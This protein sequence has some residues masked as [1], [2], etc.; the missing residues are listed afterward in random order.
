MRRW[1]SY[2]IMCY[3][4]TLDNALAPK[5]ATRN[6][7]GLDLKA[8]SHNIVPAHGKKLIDIGIKI[9]LPSNT[10]GRI[11]GRSSLALNHFIEI[12]A[13]V[14]DLDYT[15]SLKVVMANHSDKDFHIS[16]GDKIAQLIVEKIFIP[17]IVEIKPAGS[18]KSP[19][20]AERLDRGFGSS[21]K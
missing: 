15:G 5:R 20:H 1:Q 11:A 19:G 18:K 14:V 9:Y 17:K 12:L 6:S 2:T 8:P 3:E 16:R 10:Y 7:A 4:K 13:G 21:G